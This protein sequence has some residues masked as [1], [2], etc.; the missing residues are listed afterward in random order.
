[1]RCCSPSMAAIR[2]MNGA[3]FA[4]GIQRRGTGIPV[5]T[6]HREAEE[7]EATG[8]ARTSSPPFNPSSLRSHFSKRPK[9]RPFSMDKDQR[10]SKGDGVE[11]SRNCRLIGWVTRSHN[12]KL[13]D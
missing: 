9:H 12:H 4:N 2:I 7:A 8:L 11:V 1:V 13:S 6:A 10:C 3:G 5:M